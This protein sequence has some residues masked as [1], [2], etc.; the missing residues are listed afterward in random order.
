MNYHKPTGI[1]LLYAICL[2]TSLSLKAQDRA[3]F[4]EPDTNKPRLFNSLPA[5]VEVAKQDLLNILNPGTQKTAEIKLPLA[6]GKFSPFT[7]KI[8]HEISQ[9]QQRTVTIQSTNFD[10]AVLTLSSVT[11]SDGSVNFI[12]RIFSFQHGDALELQQKDNRYYWVKKNLYEMM[13]E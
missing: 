5:S 4:R 2:F 11:K 3:P 7:G 1:R 6:S 8:V 9:D 13:A 10:G 12:G